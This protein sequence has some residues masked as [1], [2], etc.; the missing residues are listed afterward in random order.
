MKK[1]AAILVLLSILFLTLSCSDAVV[2]T[3][4]LK[5]SWIAYEGDSHAIWVFDNYTFSYYEY[6]S[7]GSSDGASGDY[8]I[9]NSELTLYVWEDG[10]LV[11]IA[12]A[13]F[14]LIGNNL[15]ITADSETIAFQRL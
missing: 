2:D 9:S 14:S 6:Y 1:T 10:S 3:E 4:K 15:Y 7:D 12:F 5:G 13:Q 11:N 8:E